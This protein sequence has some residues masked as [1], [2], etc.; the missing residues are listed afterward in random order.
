MSTS[1]EA[2]DF[3]VPE[4]AIVQRLTALI[5]TAPTACVKA[6]L[7]APEI[8][9][10]EEERQVVPAVYVVYLGWAVEQSGSQEA[11][12]RVLYRHRWAITTAVSSVAR[13]RE[14]LARHSEAAP[15]LKRVADALHGW[16]P[17]QGFSALVPATPPAP[18][19]SPGFAYFPQVFSTAI[20]GAAQAAR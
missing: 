10:I 7:T 20:T 9:A 16:V 4:A 17:A 1:G 6:V 18:A 19:Y 13:M 2:L 5:A 15:I 3:S 11:R 14:S 12:Y 8:A